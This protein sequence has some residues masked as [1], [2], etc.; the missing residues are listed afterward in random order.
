[1]TDPAARIAA[2]R[3]ELREAIA[4]FDTT[5]GTQSVVRLTNAIEDIIDARIVAI[6]HLRALNETR[7]PNP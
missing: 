2:A 7:S 3:R 6:D 5:P 4:E 1:M